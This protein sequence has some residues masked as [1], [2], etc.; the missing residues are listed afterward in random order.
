[1]PDGA[2]PDYLDDY[3]NAIE[4]VN[5]DKAQAVTF[6]Q[7]CQYMGKVTKDAEIRHRWRYIL[8]AIHH[9]GVTSPERAGRI[10]ELWNNIMDE[11]TD[12]WIHSLPHDAQAKV[13]Q[14]PNA[15]KV[16]ASAMIIYIDEEEAYF[17]KIEEEEEAKNARG[18]RGDL[19][20]EIRPGDRGN[21]PL[22]P[23]PPAR[24]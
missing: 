21:V 17:R 11:Q 13:L 2:R 15:K 1:M 10:L 6:R 22:E 19:Q 8:W 14:A 4:Q 7:R 23:N 20:G 16:R 24:P 5:L 9:R 18:R 12:A 3:E